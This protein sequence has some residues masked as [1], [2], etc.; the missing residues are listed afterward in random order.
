MIKTIV[1]VVVVVLAGI[2]GYASTR[3]DTFRVQRTVS[4]KAPPEKIFARIN[5]FH[6][7]NSWSP[8]EKLDPAMKRTFSGAASGKGAAYAWEGSDKVGAGR[9]EI[10]DTSPS[11][12]LIKLDFTKPFESSNV[13]EFSVDT[14]GDSSNVTWAMYG[15]SPYVSKVMGLFVN[16]DNM[17][18]K[19][20]ETG[21]ANLK[22]TVE[23]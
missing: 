7:W 19:D 9:M 12:T 3:P 21:L 16:M 17:I 15:P 2:F 1:I 22:T 6:E 18:G 11:K 5:D 23:K 4:I 10:S 14:R 20:F 13:A 8:Y